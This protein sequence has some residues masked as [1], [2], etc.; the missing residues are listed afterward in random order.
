MMYVNDENV[1]AAAGSPFENNRS[2]LS[3]SL[4]DNVFQFQIIECECEHHTCGI[5]CEKCCAMY[6]QRP[7]M[8]GTLNESNACEKCQVF[9]DLNFILF[10]GQVYGGQNY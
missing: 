4:I 2:I 3:L 10:S 7:F 5:N 8:V 9:F 6:N 1:M